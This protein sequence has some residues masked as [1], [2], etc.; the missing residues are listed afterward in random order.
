MA[1]RVEGTEPD[2]SETEELAPAQ[3]ELAQTLVIDPID[4]NATAVI[5][6][7]VEPPKKKR[8]F[9]W[10]I[11]LLVVA[12]LLVVGFFVGDS[13]ARQ[14]A[15]DLVRDRIIEVLKLDKNTDVAV[16][17][18]GG[19]ILLQA[20][21]G[22]VNDVTVD[23]PEL[24][25]GEI[26]AAATLTAGGV[27]LDTSKPVE[28]LGITVTVT[29]EQAQALK[30]FLSG[31]ELKSIELGKGVISVATDFDVLGFLSIPVAVDLAPSATPGGI[32]FEPKTIVLDGNEISV[33]DLTAN[34]LVSALAG[35]LLQSQ[36]FC[37]AEYLPQALTIQD[38]DVIGEELV[39]Q[40]NGDGTA[41]GGSA[42]STMGVCS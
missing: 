5:E 34:P 20:L 13:I 37:V 19:S 17:L 27:P 14:Y 38:V 18:G 41:L 32:S 6:R 8:R 1:D 4:G 21:A 29:E 24:T 40:I 39:I 31:I 35:Q 2:N 42:I 3:G 16:D 25:F 7:E 26:S 23:V 11:A 30:S 9:G 33:A 22:S 12:V 28:K 36:T 15:T 10:L